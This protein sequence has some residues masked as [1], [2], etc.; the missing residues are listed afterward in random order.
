NKFPHESPLSMTLPLLLLAVPSVA[1]GFTGA[2]YANNFEAF[3]HPVGEEF[4]A[5]AAEFNWTEF[6]IMAG[7]SV[8]IALIGITLASLMYR[9]H[10]INPE[11]IAH[12]FKPL[13]QFSLNKWY[14]DELYDTVFVRN[15][16]R[17]ARQVL[18]VD[19]NVVDG[20]VNLTGF[21]AVITGEGLKYLENGRAQFYALVIFVAVLAFVV[22]SA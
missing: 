20:V 21:V 15:C 7:S 18:E 8:G 6:L 9:Q 11:A 17:L 16:R 22:I 14:F 2:P 19:F 4:V 13:Y 12:K 5:S 10:K 3:I 1:I